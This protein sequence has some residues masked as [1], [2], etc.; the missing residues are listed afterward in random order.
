MHVTTDAV[1]IIYDIG[2]LASSFFFDMMGLINTSVFEKGLQDPFSLVPFPDIESYQ[3]LNDRIT[4]F[5][6]TARIAGFRYKIR[7]TFLS[8]PLQREALDAFLAQRIG[9]KT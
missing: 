4:I 3:W 1:N 8:D 9:R 7:P 2:K 6:S 5:R